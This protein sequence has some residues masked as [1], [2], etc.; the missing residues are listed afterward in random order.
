[1]ES[2]P[3]QR[4]RDLYLLTKPGLTLLV[5]ITTLLGLAL[6]AHG[7]LPLSLVFATLLGTALTGGGACALNMAMESEHDRRMKRTA[8]RPVAAERLS[9]EEAV[10]FGVGLIGLG[11]VVLWLF[12]NP[13]T[14][15]LSLLAAAVY[16]FSYTP[17]KRGTPWATVI[18]AIPGALPPMM[19]YTAVA[20]EIGRDAWI[21]FGILF[22]WQLPHFW[23]L[24]ILYK[25]DYERGGFKLWP[26]KQDSQ[27]GVEWRVLFTTMA[28]FLSSLVL[29]AVGAAGVIYVVGAFV[30]GTFFLMQAV[31]LAFEHDRAAARRLFLTSIA[32][33]PLLIAF[34]IADRPRLLLNTLHL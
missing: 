14:A 15:L 24:L 6:G 26:G 10:V 33:L 28:L 16:L 7:T 18:G 22:F 34:L 32:Y 27:Q 9:H 2:A 21:V 25:Q 8:N 12:T 29:F 11:G 30:L 4:L 20:G 31:R 19:G 1:L 13:L 3:A 23:A 17:L 5:V